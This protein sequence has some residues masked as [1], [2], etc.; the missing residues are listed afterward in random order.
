MHT[1]FIHLPCWLIPILVGLITAILGYLLGQLFS[2]DAAK[3]KTLES[4]VEDL[5][6][7]LKKCKQDKRDLLD[8]L[9]LCK[10]QQEELKTTLLKNTA[11]EPTTTAPKQGIQETQKKKSPAKKSKTTQKDKAAPAKTTTTKT[12]KQIV[13]DADAAKLAFGKKV[14]ENDLK[15]IEGI[16]PKIAALFS[17]ANIGT[18]K[19]LSEASVATCKEVLLNGGDRFRMH[20]PD[21]WPKQAKMAYQGKWKALKEWQDKLDGGKA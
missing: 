2:G 1:L 18:W 4:D 8:Q 17:E 14:K 21:T 6:S 9:E 5:N 11:A 19:L 7:A 3:V 13:F 15:I 20:K 10:R 12:P 16:G